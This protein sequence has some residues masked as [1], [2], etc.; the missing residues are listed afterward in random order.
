MIRILFIADVIGSPGRDVV[1]AL[2][3]NLVR[4]HSVD[5]VIANGE[6]SAGGFGLTRDSGGE[7]FRA[8]VQVLTG[9]NHLW[10]RR[11]SYEY[12]ASETRLVRPANMPPGTVG[13]GW[14]VFP[15]RDGTPVGVVN[16]LGRV[17]MK[18]VDDPFRTADRALEAVGE[19][20]KVI[21]VDV[22]AETTA[23]KVA[24]GWHLDGEATAVIGTH[25]HIPTADE[26]VTAR[27]TAYLTDVGM[28]GP[29]DG[30][31]GVQKELVLQRF[32]TQMPARWEPAKGDPRLCG[33]VIDCDGGTGRARSI[34]RVLVIGKN[35]HEE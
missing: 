2:L 33:V 5:L 27:G 9:G 29:Y 15:A 4:R 14:G 23:E 26:T 22:H 16:L 34:E 3:P 24:L 28:T 7:L 6:N 25:T 20:A 18:D 13:R 32:L 11:D 30:V 12:L 19:R 17:F 8:G 31:I 21:V 35:E 1:R 10:D